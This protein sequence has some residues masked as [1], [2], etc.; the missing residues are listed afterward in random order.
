MQEN[1]T[2]ISTYFFCE[3]VDHDDKRTLPFD[4]LQ[5]PKLQMV[6]HSDSKYDGWLHK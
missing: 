5:T 3:D 2:S 6:C 4:I 1:S